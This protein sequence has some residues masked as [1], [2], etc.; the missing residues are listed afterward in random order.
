MGQNNMKPWTR[1]DLTIVPIGVNN[2]IVIACDSCG[3]IGD[4]K[5]DTLTI[6]PEYVGK[7]TTRVALTE[8]IC[9]GASPITI[10]NT[11]AC[12][13]EPTGKA[14]LKG[15]EDELKN[16]NISDI[17]VTGS[18][19]ENF[20]TNMTALGITAIGRV[21]DCGFKFADATQ[22]DKLILLGTPMVGGEVNLESKG[23]YS[24][25]KEL[26][27][28]PLVKEIIPVG[29]KGIAYEAETLANITGTSI[30]LYNLEVDYYKSAGPVTCLLILCDET[31]VEQVLSN[32]Q[33]TTLIGEVW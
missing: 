10:T 29:S 9:S 18:T 2:N 24:E 11:V 31:V 6:P 1:R 4:K 21:K 12:E 33:P 7:F 13:M 25:I 8:V 5:G 17:V 14:I 26:L 32:Y 22:G 3:A 15:I 20:T 19:E 28:I 16:A 30:T 27:S 23:F